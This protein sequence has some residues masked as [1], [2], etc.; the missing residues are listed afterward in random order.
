MPTTGAVRQRRSRRLG[1]AVPIA[2]AAA[3]SA[4]TLA[5][6]SAPGPAARPAAADTRVVSLSGIG[7]LRSVFNHDDGH[8]RLVL[9]FSPT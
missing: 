8:P 9:I 1:W 3:V 5:S 7:A 2:A 6:C 4:M